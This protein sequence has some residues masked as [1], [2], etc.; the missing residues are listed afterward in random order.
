MA[1]NPVRFTDAAQAAFALR[2]KYRNP[3]NQIIGALY[4]LLEP[5]EPSGPPIPFA[6]ELWELA[7]M[8]YGPSRVYWEEATKAFCSRYVHPSCP[9]VPGRP[10]PGVR[11][12]NAA[13]WRWR[14]LVA[15]TVEFCSDALSG[16]CMA[17]S[18]VQGRDRAAALVYAAASER[19]WPVTGRNPAVNER[20]SLPLYTMLDADL[21]PVRNMD[22]DTTETIWNG[23]FD[24]RLACSKEAFSP[25][26]QR[27]LGYL[28]SL[29]GSPGSPPADTYRI[30]ADEF[31]EWAQIE[32]CLVRE[33]FAQSSSV[34][35][36][37]HE[38]ARR[39]LVLSDRRRFDP[40]SLPRL[41]VPWW[42][43]PP[44]S[45]QHDGC[46]WQEVTLHR[47][48]LPYL[49]RL[50]SCLDQMPLTALVSEN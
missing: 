9:G 35:S 24:P 6:S 41:D 21:R 26:A 1:V 48:L 30:W 43:A 39:R 20:Y 27:F 17:E 28:V 33:A 13:T 10:R 3:H 46:W 4:D 7:A 23:L 22:A 34:L 38:I 16:W 36:P 12:V 44:Q 49:R 25:L 18:K 40:T 31:A 47:R 2:D 45:G 37:A 15:F 5:P 11:E 8:I 14:T 32:P 19:L 29:V 42:S 50:N